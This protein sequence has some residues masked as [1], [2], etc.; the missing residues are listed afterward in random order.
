V[1][2]S[3]EIVRNSAVQS[4]LRFPLTR[5]LGSSGHVRVLRALM[6]YG[7]PL[8]AAQLAADSGLTTRGTRLV[9]DSLVS[10]GMISVLGQPRSQV[11]SVAAQH[12]LAAALKTLFEEER[13]RWEAL[14]GALREGLAA[15]KDVRSAWL[16]GSVARGEDEPRSDVDIALVV[17]RE[18]LDVTDSVREAIQVLGDRLQVHF[19]TVVLTPADVANLPQ[20]DHWWAEMT[21]DAKV[22]KGIGPRQE[23]ARRARSDQPA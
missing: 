3:D 10:Q 2:Y 20:D 23:A 13:T 7:A 4:H 11:F 18:G 9:L 12:P 19:S 5:L 8:S 14:Q 21:Q 15:Q 6:V 17:N 16:Y 22:L 1:R